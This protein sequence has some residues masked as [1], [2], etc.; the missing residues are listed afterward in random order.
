MQ[1]IGAATAGTKNPQKRR[2][3]A[4]IEAI[5]AGRPTMECIP[6]TGSPKPVRGLVAN[7]HIASA[8]GI[9]AP[10][11]AKASAPKSDRIP[12]AIHAAKTNCDRARVGSHFGGLEEMPVPIIVPT[13]IAADVHGPRPRIV[14]AFAVAHFAF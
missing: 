11:S 4:A 3:P 7:R 2:S 8:S 12:P 14:R 10:S 5:E 6:R 13:T 1:K 9:A